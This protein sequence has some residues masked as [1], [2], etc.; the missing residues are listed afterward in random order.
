[1]HIRVE[2][3]AAVLDLLGAVPP[4]QVEHGR[5]HAQL[6]EDFRFEEPL[7]DDGGEVFHA[8]EQPEPFLE[9]FLFGA[10]GQSV[11]AQDPVDEP[12]D[13]LDVGVDVEPDRL[14]MFAGALVAAG[15]HRLLADEPGHLFAQALVVDRG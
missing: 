1:M 8:R 4:H 7:T 14:Q 12:A 9:P 13:L 2:D 15:V 3:H 11:F 6:F 10:T 5:V